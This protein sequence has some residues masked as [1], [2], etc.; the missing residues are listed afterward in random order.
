MRFRERKVGIVGDINRMYHT[1]K[2]ALPD[3][4]VH[5][6]LWRNLETSK[7]PVTYVMTSISFVDRQAGCIVKV[8]LR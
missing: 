6:F 7:Y 2:M 3:Q 8:A 4:H 1:L 5:R